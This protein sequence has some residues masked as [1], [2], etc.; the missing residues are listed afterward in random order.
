MT[1]VLN[2]GIYNGS[3]DDIIE[4]YPNGT[5][6]S[7]HEASTRERCKFTYW[8]GSEYQPGDQYTVEGDH[9]FT[10]QWEKEEPTP[11]PTPGPVLPRTGDNT[12]L[13]LWIMLMIA[14]LLG[15]GV[16]IFG[17]IRKKRSDN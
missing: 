14:G 10:A 13:A 8:K 1:Y 3:T 16:A 17:H 15:I 6:I 12:N 5:V 9:T 2:G 4:S 11:E 7:I